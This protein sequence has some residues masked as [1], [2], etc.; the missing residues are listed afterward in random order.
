M[1]KLSKLTWALIAGSAVVIIALVA[2][3]VTVVGANKTI[4]LNVDGKETTVQT[5]GGKVSDALSA[6]NVAVDSKDI[7]VPEVDAPLAADQTVSVQ[8]QKD[9]NVTLD[10]AQTV[11]STNGNTVKDVVTTLGVASSAKTS[12]DLS[13]NLVDLSDPL[14]ISTP[15]TVVVNVDGK[16]TKQ[17]STSPEVSDLLREMNITVG[18]MDRVS[19]PLTSPLVDGMGVKINR[20]SV[21]DGAAETEDIPFET[22]TAKDD[23]MFEGE[24]KVTKPGEIGVQET[25][26]RVTVVDGQ[27]VGREKLDTKVTKEPVTQEETVG[28]KKREAPKTPAPSGPTGPIG[29]TWAALAQCESGG[30]WAINTGNGYYGGLQFSASSWIGAGG[31]KYAP[32][33]NLATPQQQIEIAETL[34]ASGGWNHW[35]SCARK[36]GLL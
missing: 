34:R 31:G 26:Y 33:A 11:V 18:D 9:I 24:K 15:K 32:T 7:V 25:T 1:K 13:E 16:Q 3:V 27:E 12:A 14:T 19:L 8:T 23:A 2:S 17:V 21:K 30:N 29:D 36:L 20:V 22:K 28:T 35:P 5:M 10:G 6:A 4:Q